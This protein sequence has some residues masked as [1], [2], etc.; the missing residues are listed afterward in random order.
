MFIL[1]FDLWMLW[2]LSWWKWMWVVW[3]VMGRDVVLCMR[4]IW[5]CLWCILCI[6][7]IVGDYFC[8]MLRCKL[9]L[10]CKLL[11]S[12]LGWIIEVVWWL[13]VVLKVLCKRFCMI[14]SICWS[15][16]CF[17]GNCWE[18]WIRWRSC[19][20]RCWLLILMILMCL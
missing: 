13:G 11:G 17:C 8:C 12:I 15:L 18:M 5:Y 10:N 9:K 20:R 14:C 1:I 6:I 2:V 4:M 3:S 7:R 19:I 16:L